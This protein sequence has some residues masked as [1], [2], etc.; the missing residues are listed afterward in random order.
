MTFHGRSFLQ[1]RGGGRNKKVKTWKQ[2]N[3]IFRTTGDFIE[4]MEE[5]KKEDKEEYYLLLK[6]T[7]GTKKTWNRDLAQKNDKG[8]IQK[9]FRSELSPQMAPFFTPADFLFEFQCDIPLPNNNNNESQR[10]NYYSNIPF[11][12]FGDRKTVY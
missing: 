8:A 9:K 7:V 5:G 1:R 2:N 3:Y 10:A 4:E 12:P 11:V 6:S